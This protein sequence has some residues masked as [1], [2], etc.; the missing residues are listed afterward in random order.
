MKYTVSYKVDLRVDVD[1]DADTLEDAMKKAKEGYTE[2]QDLNTADVVDIEPVN[3]SN[4]SG[5][6]LADF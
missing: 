1:I 6:L 5:E 2:I 3:I 4:E